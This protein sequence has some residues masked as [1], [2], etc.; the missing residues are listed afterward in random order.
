MRGLTGMYQ[1]F[2]GLALLS[3]SGR[4]RAPNIIDVNPLVDIPFGVAGK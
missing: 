4:G 1:A 2:F 3:V